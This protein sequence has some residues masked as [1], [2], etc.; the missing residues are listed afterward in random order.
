MFSF[1][2]LC[3]TCLPFYICFVLLAL[4]FSIVAENN[5][6]STS[7]M[8]Y[9]SMKI[10]KCFL[11]ITLCFPITLL[12]Y[13]QHQILCLLS[14][15]V[16]LH[17]SHHYTVLFSDLAYFMPHNKSCSLLLK[18]QNIL[19]RI[20]KCQNQ[21]VQKSTY[22][23]FSKVT[24]LNWNCCYK[25]H[26]V[27]KQY[28]LSPKPARASFIENSCNYFFDK[29]LTVSERCSSNSGSSVTSD[30]MKMYNLIKQITLGYNL[31]GNLFKSLWFLSS[32]WFIT[33]RITW[34]TQLLYHCERLMT[35][36]W[37]ST[38]ESKAKKI[39]SNGFSELR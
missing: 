10:P 12:I 21:R 36:H 2:F 32:A 38:L 8:L 17:M 15:S 23:L 20:R 13:H 16:A 35:F 14:L 30:E 19:L 24:G 1:S 33:W 22:F 4:L 7:G 34:K 5:M 18:T 39:N 27:L 3:S 25:I 6:A 29:I 26:T 11:S 9:R 37:S 28:S 31:G